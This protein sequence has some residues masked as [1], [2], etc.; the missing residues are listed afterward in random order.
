MQHSSSISETAK[1]AGWHPEQCRP[2]I[3][4]PNAPLRAVFE[5]DDVPLL[6]PLNAHAV[7]SSLDNAIPSRC[8]TRI[9]LHM[10]LFCTSGELTRAVVPSGGIGVGNS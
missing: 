7:R 10:T 8:L 5:F 9:M 4:R 2:K 3:A 6:V 1:S